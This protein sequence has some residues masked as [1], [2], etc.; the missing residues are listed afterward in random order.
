MKMVFIALVCF[1]AAGLLVLSIVDRQNQTEEVT[2]QP[3]FNE[4]YTRFGETF[5]FNKSSNVTT[6]ENDEMICYMPGREVSGGYCIPKAAKIRK[7][8]P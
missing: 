6:W 8:Y 4:T 5:T 1:V 2:Y 7:S 3:Q